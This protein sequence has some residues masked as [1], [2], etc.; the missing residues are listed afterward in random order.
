MRQKVSLFI[1][2]TYKKSTISVTNI[3]HRQYQTMSKLSTD[4]TESKQFKIYRRICV[5]KP[6]FTYLH[7]DFTSDVKCYLP[8]L[9]VNS[10]ALP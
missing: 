2:T 9:P 3:E 6:I 4:G 7:L 5:R 8:V 10:V 1:I